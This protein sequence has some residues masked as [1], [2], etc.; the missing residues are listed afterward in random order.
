[1]SI[2]CYGLDCVKVDLVDN[3]PLSIV[4][5]EPYAFDKGYESDY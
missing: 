2:E 3:F 4:N 1:M 5:D